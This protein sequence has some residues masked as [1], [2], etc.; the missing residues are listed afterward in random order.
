MWTRGKGLGACLFC[1]SEESDIEVPKGG[2]SA[3][4]FYTW[5]KPAAADIDVIEKLG[6]PGWNFDQYQKYSLMSETYATC[7]T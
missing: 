4:N 1:I 5:N 7:L 6:N 3:L 2:T